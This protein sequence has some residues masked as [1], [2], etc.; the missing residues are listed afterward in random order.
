MPICAQCGTEFGRLP[1]GRAPRY[2]SRACQARAYRA[3]RA[4][5]EPP[6]PEVSER[7]PEPSRTGGGLTVDAIVRAAVRIADADG[8]EALSMR[9]VAEACDVGTMALYHHVDGKDALIELMVEA[10]YAASGTPERLPGDW[11]AELA[12]VARA[13]WA[14][15][16]AHPWALQVL[17]SVQPP[18]V[19][20]V[21]AGVERAMAALDGHGLDPLTVHRIAQSVLGQVQG[22]G[23]LRVSEIESSRAEGPSLAQWRASVAP[24]ALR[25]QDGDGPRFPRL[26]SLERIPE[27]AADLDGL[28]EFS[29]DRLL[30]G[31]A[32][33]LD[34]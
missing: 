26:A 5:P 1:R 17:A 22:L 23:L 6:R 3:R 13:E 8:L 7:E 16:T 19:P 25:R 27:A 10:V 2:C 32:P 30:D 11:R 15:Y 20:S 12:R 18:L 4:E 24:V 33:L 29:L 28:F 21:L 34:R 31:I 9:R 14:L